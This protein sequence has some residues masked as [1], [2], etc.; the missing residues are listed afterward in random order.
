MDGGDSGSLFA[1]LKCI[2]RFSA[3]LPALI[4]YVTR[5]RE[6]RGFEASDFN[7]IDLVDKE[8]F[9]ATSPD[10]RYRVPSYGPLP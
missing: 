2:K 8:T 6:C 5:F 4:Y 1:L 10:I 7:L 9:I 3:E